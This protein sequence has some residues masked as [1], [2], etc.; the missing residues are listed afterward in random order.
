MKIGLLF[1]TALAAG[2]TSILVMF[3]GLTMLVALFLDDGRRGYTIELA[4]RLIQLASVLIG[5]Q[6]GSPLERSSPTR[7][8][9]PSCLTRCPSGTDS[10]P[11]PA[12]GRRTAYRRAK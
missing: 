10:T 1:R 3:F 12:A 8:R 4:D 11:V 2:P 7:G 9:A 6:E 5:K